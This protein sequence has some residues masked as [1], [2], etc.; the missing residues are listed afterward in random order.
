VRRK[1]KNKPCFDG[2]SIARDEDHGV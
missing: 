2:S 1:T